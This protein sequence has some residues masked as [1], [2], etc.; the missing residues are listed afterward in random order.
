MELGKGEWV[1]EDDLYG[2][3]DRMFAHMQSYER[4]FT[5]RCL[6]PNSVTTK[7]YQLVEIPKRLLYLASDFP[8]EMMHDSRQNPKPG[9]CRVDE[10]GLPAFDLYFDGG[11]E[12]KLQ[13]RKLRVDLCNVHATWTVTL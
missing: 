11:T 13:V 2:L 12:R 6:T 10:G 5:L 1:T 8:C 4:I 3:R 9:Y 7:V